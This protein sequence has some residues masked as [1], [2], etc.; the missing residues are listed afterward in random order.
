ME[1]MNHGKMYG[2]SVQPVTDESTGLE[3]IELKIINILTINQYIYYLY[4]MWTAIKL[5]IT[6][7]QIFFYLIVSLFLW[8]GIKIKEGL[9][10][11]KYVDFS[12]YW[13]SH[14]PR[15]L[16]H[17]GA[18]DRRMFRYQAWNAVEGLLMTDDRQKALDF[19]MKHRGTVKQCLNKSG[20]PLSHYIYDGTGIVVIQ[21]SDRE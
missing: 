9:F 12:D 15:Q 11:S 17:P 3:L 13:E 21:Q 5:A 1:V 20:N 10:M 6:L 4:N 19:A 2:L 18:Y 7:S 14:Y 8:I 16:F